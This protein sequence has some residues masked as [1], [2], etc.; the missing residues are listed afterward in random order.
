MACTTYIMTVRPVTWQL[1]YDPKPTEIHEKVAA[2]H[3]QCI[4]EDSLVEAGVIAAHVY[5]YA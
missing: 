1:K 4:V 3:T 5:N 2:A